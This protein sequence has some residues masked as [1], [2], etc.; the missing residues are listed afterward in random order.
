[1]SLTP[2]QVGDIAHL[3]R[4]QIDDQQIPAYAETLSSI[5]NLVQALEAADTSTVEPM[6]HPIAAGQRLRAD[7]VSEP[8]V[9]EDVRGN[10]SHMEDGLYLVPK[11]IE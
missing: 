2:K 10:T 8:D 11:V 4:L 1:M 9:R 7:R 3:A 6:A 5:L